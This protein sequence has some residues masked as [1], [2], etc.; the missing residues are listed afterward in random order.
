MQ[1]ARRAREV[2][3]GRRRALMLVAIVAVA[4]LLAGVGV[5]VWQAQ[6][7]D[8]TTRPKLVGPEPSAPI[9]TRGADKPRCRSPLTPDDPLRLWIGGD[10]LAGSLG[11]ALGD[12]TAKSGVVLPTFDSRPSSGL[13]SASFFDWPKH[14]FAEMGRVDPEVVVFIIGANDFSFAQ[15]KPVDANRQPLWRRYYAALVKQMLDIFGAGGRPVYWIGA[16]PLREDR[17]DAGVREVNDVASEVVARTPEASYIDAYKLFSDDNGKYTDTLPGLNGKPIRV[18][19]SDGIHFTPAG[20]RV[21]A[22]AVFSQLDARCR[23][24]EQAVPGRRQPVREAPGSS[25]RPP[26][27]APPKPSRPATTTTAT[28]P[29]PPPTT[30]TPP[31]TI[32]TVPMT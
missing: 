17:K 28:T 4:A 29:V 2:E 19:T 12:Q 16:P 11:P 27:S 24:T 9:T 18:R 30:T 1:R 8:T 25:Q 3:R 13:T 6:L 23:I 26:T 20:A 5:W 14:A 31:T 10:S 21:L 32:I 15:S 7:A 22:D